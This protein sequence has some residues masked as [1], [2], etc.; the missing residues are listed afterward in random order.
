M[1]HIE[2]GFDWS[3]HLEL[4]GRWVTRSVLR[5]IGPARQSKALCM[6]KLLSFTADA[7]PAVDGGPMW[8]LWSLSAGLHV[9]A[10]RS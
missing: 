4:T 6:K 1:A 7:E 8:P 9:H 2:A 10:Q 5:G 3:E